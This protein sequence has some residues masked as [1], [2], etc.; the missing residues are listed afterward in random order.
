MPTR[1]SALAAEEHLGPCGGR[2]VVQV[3]ESDAMVTEAQCGLVSEVDD[4]HLLK[5][6]LEVPALSYS[7]V[8]RAVSVGP[9]FSITSSFAASV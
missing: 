2:G 6:L 1:L 4:S 9:R 8:Y 7:I 3:S 5:L